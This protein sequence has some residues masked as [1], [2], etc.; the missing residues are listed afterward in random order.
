MAIKV[1][2]AALLALVAV[3][4][5]LALFLAWQSGRMGGDGKRDGPY[6]REEKLEILNGLAGSSSDSLS[7]DEKMEVLENLGSE[8]STV[9]VEKK[10][11]ILNALK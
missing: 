6:S 11:E 5:V 1:M 3:Y 9:S 4:A 2:F 7:A 8:K 10:A